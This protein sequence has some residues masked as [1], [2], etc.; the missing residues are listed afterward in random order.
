MFSNIRV[1]SCCSSVAEVLAVVT[2]CGG[3]FM[4][5]VLCI[6]IGSNEMYVSVDIGWCSI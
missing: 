4:Q 6:W 1:D 3:R 2:A 5:R